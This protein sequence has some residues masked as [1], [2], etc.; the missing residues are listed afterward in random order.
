M[1]FLLRHER[2]L[3]LLAGPPGKGDQAHALYRIDEGF[4]AS[5]L[6]TTLPAHSEG[7][8]VE[9]GGLLL[10]MDGDGS[11]GVPCKEP[12]RWLRLP[13]RREDLAPADPR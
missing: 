10:V 3:L 1:T 5:P 11:P 4:A 2:S 12:A 13:L 8:V 9:E 6:S 7:L